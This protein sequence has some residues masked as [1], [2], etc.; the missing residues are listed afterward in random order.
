MSAIIPQNETALHAYVL[1]ANAQAARRALAAGDWDGWR[2][3]VLMVQHLQHRAGPESLRR[4]AAGTARALT[5]APALAMDQG[6]AR[7]ARDAP[8]GTCWAFRDH[9]PLSA[10]P[11]QNPDQPPPSAA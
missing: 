8:P 6:P 2:D 9:R 10:L 5:S 7:P 11:E 4:C 3:N 1:W